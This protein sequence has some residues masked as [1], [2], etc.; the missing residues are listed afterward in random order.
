MKSIAAILLSSEKQFALSPNQRGHC[1]L[2]S[3]RAT[4]AI[5]VRSFTQFANTASKLGF[6]PTRHAGTWIERRIGSLIQQLDCLGDNTLKNGT[7]FKYPQINASRVAL[8]PGINPSVRE[9]IV[10]H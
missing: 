6:C 9:P 2:S 8:R 3:L 4:F 10:L 7:T 5:V 1:R